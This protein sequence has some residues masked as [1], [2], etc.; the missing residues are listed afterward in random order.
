[1][2]FGTGFGF[3]PDFAAETVD[4]VE[5]AIT[6]PEAKHAFY[7]GNARR[8]LRLERVAVGA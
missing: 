4:D 8:V 5:T 3:S 1:V 7:E 6:D 2:L